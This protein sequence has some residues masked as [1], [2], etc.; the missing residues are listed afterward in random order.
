MAAATTLA[1]IQVREDVAD[2]WGRA[3]RA[4]EVATMGGGAGAAARDGQGAESGGGGADM[5]DAERA[6]RAFGVDGILLRGR[7][8]RAMRASIGL[9]ARELAALVGVS[10]QTVYAYEAEA[11]EIPPAM[12]LPLVEALAA[13]RKRRSRWLRVAWPERPGASGV[14]RLG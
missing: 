9:S 4:A 8:V 5:D 12:Y 1:S 6:V 7:H 13:E 14:H 3:E 11:R 10:W 2:V